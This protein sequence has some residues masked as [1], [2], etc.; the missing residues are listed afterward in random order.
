MAKTNKKSQ[1]PKKKQ[2]SV[3]VEVDQ[4]EKSDSFEFTP[5]RILELL[6]M[7]LYALLI[8]VAKSLSKLMYE[9]ENSANYNWKTDVPLT[10]LILTG[11]LTCLF[12]SNE[13]SKQKRGSGLVGGMACV[14]A[15]LAFHAISQ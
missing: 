15:G 9:D 7:V 13:F 12:L 8:A 4:G 14:G 3:D 11:A 2:I 5:A 1:P 10:F 6:K